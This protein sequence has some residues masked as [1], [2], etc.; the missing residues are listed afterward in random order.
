M[1]T[2]SFA[3]PLIAADSIERLSYTI[4]WRL[5]HAGNMVVES[6][7]TSEVLKL[8][9]AGM[10]SA[11][12]KID[13]TYRVQFDSSF[14]A[15]SS[16]MNS[17]EG[18]RHRETSINF[19]R[20]RNRAFLTEKDLIKNTI[21][22]RTDVQIPTCAHEVITALKQL[23]R[24]K[25]EIGQ[26]V[27]IPVSDGRKSAAVRVEAQERE[28]VTTPAGTFNAI[29]YEVNLLNG[30]VYSRA[31]RVFVWLTDDE[32]RL[33]VQFRLRMNFPLGTVT[34]GLEKEEHP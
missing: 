32:R 27:Q 21:V 18:S 7:P 14:C 2:L 25:V 16:L 19:D 34:L 33:P 26:S 4:E 17:K 9:S 11:L 8:E 23:R 3:L 28:R 15:A 6:G 22:S 30:V 20:N 13:D 12:Y 5:I 10:V 29:R 24:T 31:G 1:A